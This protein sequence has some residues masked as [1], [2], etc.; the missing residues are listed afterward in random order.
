MKIAI[1][2]HGKMGK[3]I[4]QQAK[5]LNVQVSRI[6]DSKEDLQRTTFNSD[7]VAIE[8]T[9][10]ESCMENF[11]ILMQKKVPVICGTTGWLNHISEVE[12]L[13]KKNQGAFLYASNFSIGVHL[14]WR[15]LKELSKSMNAFSQYDVSI[16]EVHHTQKKDKPSGTG[17]TCA[18][19]I[20]QNISRIKNQPIDSIRE[21]M[22]VGDHHVTF[23]S[24][25][26]TIEISHKAK[27]RA[28]FARGSIACA[29]WIFGKKGFFTIDDYL[30]ETLK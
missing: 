4:E 17:K 24:P 6:I 19:I 7:E 16:R 21:G 18:D 22:V 29:Q 10:P 3:E 25:E 28:G 26:D 20:T 1:I 2:G 5:L 13:V 12:T 14:F 27:S 8:F 15:A 23:D 11:Q 9:S 30:K